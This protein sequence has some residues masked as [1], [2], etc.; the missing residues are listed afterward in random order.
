MEFRFFRENSHRELKEQQRWSHRG[1]SSPAA[2]FYGFFF[3][4]R[5]LY[6]LVSSFSPPTEFLWVKLVWS[7]AAHKWRHDSCWKKKKYLDTS[8]QVKLALSWGVPLPG[9]TLLATSNLVYQGQQ[10][11]AEC[12]KGD[13]THELIQ[14]NGTNTDVVKVGVYQATSTAAPLTAQGCKQKLPISFQRVIR[15][16]L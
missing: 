3:L 5:L 6:S 11:F 10:S 4:R 15:I 14:D 13:E 8:L 1:P 9:R 7:L 16:L 12:W 2:D